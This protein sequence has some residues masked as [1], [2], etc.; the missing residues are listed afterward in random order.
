[1]PAKMACVA[2]PAS[3]AEATL[4]PMPTGDLRKCQA[5]C[6]DD[7]GVSCTVVVVRISAAAGTRCVLGNGLAEGPGG[8]YVATGRGRSVTALT[9]GGR[10]KL[11]S[12]AT[13]FCDVN[14]VL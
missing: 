11:V 4:A 7:S 1:M 9:L 3:A 10:C 2:R 6:G 8:E 13:A 12:F 14:K 5:F